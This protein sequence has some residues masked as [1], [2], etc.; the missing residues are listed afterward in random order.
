M[1]PRSHIEALD[2]SLQIAK[3]LGFKPGHHLNRPVLRH[4]DLQSNNTI[5][6]ESLDIVGLVDWQHGTIAPLSLAAGIPHHFQ[7]YEDPE[8]ERLAKPARD[9][10]PNFN[11]LDPAQQ[12]ASKDLHIRRLTH[13][14][15]AALTLNHNPEH[16][17]AIFDKSVILLQRLYKTAGSAWEGDSITL[18]A[19]LINALQNWAELARVHES[20]APLTYSETDVH[21]ILN[22]HARQ[23]EMDTVMDQMRATLG[24]D[25]YG[26]TSNEDYEATKAM[27]RDIKDKMIPHHRENIRRHFPFDD[28]D[29]D[30]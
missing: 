20:P 27:A 21:A 8:S 30:A 29:E 3:H 12:I 13:F 10:P 4:P 26:W 11:S 2:R 18:A 23:Q 22:L 24:V 16:Y 14:L 7:N 9:L 17:D 5:L 25:V 19:E 6:S 1:S 15:Y 28:F